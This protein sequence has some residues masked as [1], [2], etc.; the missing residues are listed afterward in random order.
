[1][2]KDVEKKK[3]ITP[4]LLQN[5]YYKMCKN[6]KKFKIKNLN[7][8]YLKNDEILNFTFGINENKINNN[9]KNVN[10]NILNENI[11][12]YNTFNYNTP[13]FNIFNY[14]KNGN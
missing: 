14:N 8:F 9:N 1:M 7:E 4:F 3:L 13:D 5:N 11:E 12:N 6:V 10:E 2:L